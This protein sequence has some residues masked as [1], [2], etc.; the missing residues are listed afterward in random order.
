MRASTLLLVILFLGQVSPAQFGDIFKKKPAGNS[1]TLSDDKISAGLKE[2]LQI[3]TAHAVALAGKPDGFLKNDAIHIPLPDKLKSVGRGMRLIGMGA[4]VD[5]LEVGMNRA[6][7]QAAPQAKTIFLA[8][9]KRMTFDDARKILSGGDT[10]ATAYFKQASTPELTQ[11]FTPIVHRS[12]ANLGVMKQYNAIVQSAPG[13]AALAG[14]FDLD[15]YVV[16]KA[17][18]GLFYMLAQEEQKIRKDPAA[19]TTS[20]LRAVFGRK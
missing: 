5:E 10:A 19:Q 6:A 18:D 12:L 13:G 17:L 20:L 3:S 9:L 16:G 4:Q 14:R 8:A 1:S 2:A 7:E 15:Q 11:A